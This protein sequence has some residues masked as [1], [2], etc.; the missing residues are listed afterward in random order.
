MYQKKYKI[1][2]KSEVRSHRCY[3]CNKTSEGS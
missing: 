1:A 3:R 2:S